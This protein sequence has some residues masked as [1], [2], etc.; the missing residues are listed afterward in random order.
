MKKNWRWAK[1]KV[2]SIYGDPRHRCAV[3]IIFLL[4][5]IA[6]GYLAFMNILMPTSSIFA[7]VFAALLMVFLLLDTT[8]YVFSL[9]FSALGDRLHLFRIIDPEINARIRELEDSIMNLRPE[10]QEDKIASAANDYRSDFADRQPLGRVIVAFLRRTILNLLVTILCFT[11]ITIGLAY[12]YKHYGT[13]DIYTHHCL[14]KCYNFPDL[15]LHF[16]YYHSV[17]F[18]SLGDGNHAPQTSSAQGIA[19][20]EAF[21]AFFYLIL[22]IGGSLSVS[23]FV[24]NELAPEKLSEALK[25]RLADLISS[26]HPITNV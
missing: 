16:F 1:D 10:E 2:F 11:G 22:I 17:I 7:I 18:Q 20:V 12:W 14:D 3:I 24:H 13:Q 21:V 5:G 4:S 15:I 25:D 9:L 19:I 26:K 6:S 23:M 8:F